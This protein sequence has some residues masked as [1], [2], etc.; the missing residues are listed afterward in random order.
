MTMPEPEI[1]RNVGLPVFISVIAIISGLLHALTTLMGFWTSSARV[2]YG[3]AQLNQLPKQLMKLNKH[4]QP[5]ICNLVVLL[6]GIFF[7]LFTGDN[8]VQYIYAVSCIAAGLV[9]GIV[10]IDAIILRNRHPEWERPFVAPGGNTLFGIGIITSAW[11]IVGSVLELPL[12]GYIALAIYLV[13]GVAI[14]AIMDS[15]RKNNRE[16]YELITLTPDDVERMA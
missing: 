3:A 14:S 4:G 8:W 9:Y 7:C 13:I 10:C 2:I 11:I 6:F 12:G 1:V 5:Y 15:L 16:E